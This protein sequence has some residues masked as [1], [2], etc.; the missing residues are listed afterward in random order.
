MNTHATSILPDCAD[1]NVVK[2]I[3]YLLDK[4]VVVLAALSFL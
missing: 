1:T 4:Y 2:H 3:S